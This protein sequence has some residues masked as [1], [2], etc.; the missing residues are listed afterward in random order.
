MS[1]SLVAALLALALLAPA[2][3]LVLPTGHLPDAG[4]QA[5][6]GHLPDAGAQV[7]TG[8]QAA[9][10]AKADLLRERGLRGRAGPD[11]QAAYDRLRRARLTPLALRGAQGGEVAFLVEVAADPPARQRGL[12]GRTRLA[13]DEGML[14]AFP[15]DTDG[16]FWMKDTHIPLSIAF[17]AADGEVLRIMD[18]DP[19]EADP[20]PV[21]RPGVT[22]RYALEVNQGA[23]EPAGV[24]PGWHAAIPDDLPEPR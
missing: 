17:V 6:T 23:F 14:F 1:R 10:A 8:V 19:C 11:R 22:Y 18:M 9:G 3:G 15:D 2:S 24:G 7:A 5:V 21:Y 4:A 13:A 16:G 20:C 12:M